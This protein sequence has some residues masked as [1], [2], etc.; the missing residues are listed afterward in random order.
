MF[1]IAIKKPLFDILTD[2][3]FV[4]P[5][6]IVAFRDYTTGEDDQFALQLIDGDTLEGCEAHARDRERIAEIAPVLS[7]AQDELAGDGLLA[8]LEAMIG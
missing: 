6:A 1:T 5:E 2:K 8:R 3:G 7:V 4:R